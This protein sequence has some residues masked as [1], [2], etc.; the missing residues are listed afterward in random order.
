MQFVD[1]N[2]FMY[3]VGADHPYKVPSLRFFE[4]VAQGK[5]EIA[6]SAEVLQEILYRFWA[7]RRMDEGFQ[8]FDYAQSLCHWVLPVTQEEVQKAKELMV[9]IPKISPRDAIHVATMKK[10]RIS[11][12]ISYD[13]GF[14]CVKEIKRIEP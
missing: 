4:T 5:G 7:I 12:I 13:Q 6:I 9:G 8:L 11:T 2:I 10:N 14:D 3:A 1:T